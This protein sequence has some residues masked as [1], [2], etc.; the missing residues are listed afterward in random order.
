VLPLL[1][2]P[3]DLKIDTIDNPA[4]ARILVSY[5]KPLEIQEG[6]LVEPIGVRRNI[7]ETYVECRLISPEQ[8]AKRQMLSSIEMSDAPKRQRSVRDI[9]HIMHDMPGC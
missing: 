5:Q 3:S 8:K 4:L 7:N 9:L 6:E 1:E 2:V